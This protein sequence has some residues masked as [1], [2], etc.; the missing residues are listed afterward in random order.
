MKGGNMAQSKQ[1][2]LNKAD[3][4]S[5]A[6]TVAMVA[7]S[8]VLPT[9]IDIV[10]KTD[11]GQYTPIIVPLATLGLKTIQKLLAGK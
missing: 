2:H 3:V 7:L 10:A 8:A 5:I 1:Y 11:F 9:L 6:I 4:K